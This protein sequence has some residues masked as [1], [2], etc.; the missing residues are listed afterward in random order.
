[1]PLA[2]ALQPFSAVPGRRM[3]ALPE[4]E[5]H[6]LWRDLRCIMPSTSQN[7]AGRAGQLC[8]GALQPFDALLKH[9]SP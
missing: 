3:A 7:R 5:T 6:L 2:A 4:E 1:M 9:D 8:N